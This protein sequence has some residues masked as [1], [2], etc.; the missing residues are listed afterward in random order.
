MPK[1]WRHDLPRQLYAHRLERVQQRHISGKV[2]ALLVEWLDQQLELPQGKWCKRFP[3]MTVSGEG[4][5]VETI[6]L[7]GQAPLVEEVQ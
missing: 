2:L 5:L 6:L 4:E 1:V 7:R 3:G